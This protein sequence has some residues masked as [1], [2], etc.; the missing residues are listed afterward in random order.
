MR[1]IAALALVG[2]LA[3][4]LVAC[5]DDTSDIDNGG[6]ATPPEATA[7][8]IPTPIPT[9]VGVPTVTAD[10]LQIIDVLVGDGQ[11][12]QAADT[13]TAH[14][15]GYLD[16]GTVFDSSVTRGQPAQFSLDPNSPNTVIKGWQEGVPGMKVGGKRRLIIPSDLAYGAA[17]RGSIPGGAQLTFDIELVSIP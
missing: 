3:A 5:E 10:G 12:A 17:G 14:Y 15:T 13:V 6:G 4:G 11:E 16:N 2:V 8:A 9:V 7:T 1:T